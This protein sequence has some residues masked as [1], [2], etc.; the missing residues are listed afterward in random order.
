MLGQLTSW[1]DGNSTFSGNASPPQRALHQPS[2]TASADAG[3]KELF[4]HLRVAPHGTPNFGE[5]SPNRKKND[6]ATFN[7]GSA[8]SLSQRDKSP[9]VSPKWLRAQQFLEQGRQANFGQ[10]SSWR[11]GDA[12]GFAFDG[13]QVRQSN[14][15][16][17]GR[18]PTDQNAGWRQG[19]ASGFSLSGDGPME[20]PL[21]QHLRPGGVGR[22]FIPEIAPH[23]D[24]SLLKMPAAYRD[25]GDRYRADSRAYQLGAGGSL[26]IEAVTKEE[27]A[28]AVRKVTTDA[29]TKSGGSDWRT[30]AADTKPFTLSG[31][32][33]VGGGGEPL[34]PR[35]KA[36]DLTKGGEDVRTLVQRNVDFEQR[37]IE[38]PP[39]QNKSTWRMGDEEPFQID[40]SQARMHENHL[41]PNQS[42]WRQPDEKLPPVFELSVPVSNDRAVDRARAGDEAPFPAASINGR[43]YTDMHLHG[44]P[45]DTGPRRRFDQYQYQ[46]QQAQQ[47]EGFTWGPLAA[48]PRLDTRVTDPTISGLSWGELQRRGKLHPSVSDS[49]LTRAPGHQNQ[50]NERFAR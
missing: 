31:E 2:T 20:P 10:Q 32:A 25:Q 17:P 28:E 42:A 19:E 29:A 24:G 34:D 15:N 12:G 48:G 27:H 18:P 49:A 46:A 6:L 35:R 8:L 14:A 43:R 7:D 39:D 44:K 33:T 9:N 16:Q 23:N 50:F 36:T 13:I 41:N 26:V 40:H 47:T 30:G 37:L 1:W 3:H 21:P 11:S 45:E 22:R 4:G 38:Y 5:R